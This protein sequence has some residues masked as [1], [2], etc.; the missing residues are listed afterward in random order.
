MID[1]AEEEENDASD[2]FIKD[3]QD[4]GVDDLE[5]DDE[6]FDDYDED[7]EGTDG[8]KKAKSD[9]FD[10]ENYDDFIDDKF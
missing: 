8:E 9:S 10:N 6:N 1:I 2:E 4:Y 3:Y 5:S 7:E